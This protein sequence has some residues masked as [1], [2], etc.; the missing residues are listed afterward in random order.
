MLS[1]LIISV[2]FAVVAALSAAMTMWRSQISGSRNSLFRL[3]IVGAITWG[4]A[5]LIILYITR[6]GLSGEAIFQS[7]L[8]ALVYFGT[9][10]F[11]GR[12]RPRSPSG[13]VKHQK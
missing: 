9:I 2:I 1:T 4:A 3:A 5:V 7:L 11:I 12:R 8:T 10:M 6:Q 13:M